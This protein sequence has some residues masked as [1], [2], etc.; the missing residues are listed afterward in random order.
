VT[1]CLSQSAVKK[2]HDEYALR[3]QD[4]T[5]LAPNSGF[6]PRYYP[7]EVLASV[8]AIAGDTGDQAMMTWADSRLDEMQQRLM[9]SNGFLIW[10]DE[11]DAQ[12]TFGELAQSRL[13][14]SMALIYKGTSKMAARSIALLAFEALGR[15][16]LADV[17]SSVTGKAYHLPYYALHDV[18]HPTAVSGRSL[19]P[20]HDAALAAA[21]TAMASFVLGDQAAADAAT[22]KADGYL[23]AATDLATSTNCLPLADLPEYR[24]ACDTRYNGF[25]SFLLEVVDRDRPQSGAAQVADNQFLFAR[26]ALRSFVT[27]RVYPERLDGPYPDPVEPILW[28]PTAARGLARADFQAFV[29]KTNELILKGDPSKWPRGSLYPKFYE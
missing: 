25:W 3:I 28:F 13:V 1:A 2:I 17:Q 18:D 15:I 24:D 9:A 22:A 29:I 6:D 26:D 4:G 7:G 11:I 27:H 14:L 12:P 8:I 21:Y 23:A 5:I 20:N 16:P 10:P 19:D